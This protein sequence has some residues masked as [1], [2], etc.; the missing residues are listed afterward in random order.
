MARHIRPMC[1]AILEPKVPLF[2]LPP[3]RSSMRRPH[4]MGVLG[5]IS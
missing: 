4:W 1:L 5:G 2:I 3:I